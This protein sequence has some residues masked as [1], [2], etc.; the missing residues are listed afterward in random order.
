MISLT[1]FLI[2]I[3]QNVETNPGPLSDKPSFKIIS[4]NCNGLGNPIKVKQ[5]LH[6]LE[7]TVNNNGIVFLQETHIV[8]SNY[9]KLIWKNSFILNC[10][11]TN[12]AGVIILFNNEMKIIEKSEDEEGRLIVAVIEN[13]ERKL[14][15]VNAYYPNDHKEGIKFAEKMYLNILEMQT[16]Y[17]EHLVISAG[18]YNVCMTENDL[19]NRKRTKTEQLLAEN[20]V[21]NNKIAKLKDAFREKQPKNGF[22]WKRGNCYSR[23]DHIFVS[24]ELIPHVKKAILDWCL[25]KSDHAAVIIEIVEENPTIRGPGIVKL[26]TKTLEDPTVVREIENEVKQ[27]M[28]QTDES[29]NPHAKLE[30]LKVAIRSIVSAK[31]SK[32]RREI[33]E[34]IRDCEEEIN[35]MEN[36]NIK[37]ITEQSN[38]DDLCKKQ[39]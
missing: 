13:E 12:S 31:T 20:L 10:V 32:I 38:N 1:I 26:N 25:D 16:K 23:L 27:M 34:D 3:S 15:V 17:P 39:T 14:I 22:T 33:K 30:F 2:L 21:E 8:N 28:D 7:A 37:I 18:D 35:Q 11:K 24:E 9:V 29:W 19:L 6:K 36:L 5:L 4:Y